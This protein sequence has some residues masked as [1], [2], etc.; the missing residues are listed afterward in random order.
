MKLYNKTLSASAV[1][2]S[3]LLMTSCSQEATEQTST[4][5]TIP[6]DNTS[7]VDTNTVI[8]GPYLALSSDEATV[9]EGES[10]TL[11]IEIND[12]PVSEGGAVTLRFN[13]AQ[14]QVTTVS[15]DSNVWD[16]VNKDGQINN[17]EGT[18]SD[19]LFSSYQGVSGDAKV[20]T[21]EFRSIKNGT[22]EITLEESP[23]NPFASNGQKMV[24]SFKTTTVVAN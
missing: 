10:F 24:V 18:V 12:F 11:D 23:V 6:S 7:I 17:A 20:A 4:T 19:I 15:V 2:L 5:N 8:T 13:P 16:F 1:F 3:V 21:V 9:N 22:S 14:I